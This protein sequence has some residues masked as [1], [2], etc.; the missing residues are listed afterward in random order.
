[1]AAKY[2]DAHDFFISDC[3]NPTFYDDLSLEKI[4]CHSALQLVLDSC[5]M[6]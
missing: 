6:I 2:Y 3:I 4:T 5:M 1:M